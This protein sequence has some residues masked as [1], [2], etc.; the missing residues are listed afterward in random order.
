M[1]QSDAQ[2]A[3]VTAI[4]P[5]RETQRIDLGLQQIRGH[6]QHSSAAPAL[7]DSPWTASAIHVATRMTPGSMDRG[8]EDWLSWPGE[9]P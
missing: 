5:S 6:F 1:Q 9:E 7:L 4:K 8:A 3:F 2:Q